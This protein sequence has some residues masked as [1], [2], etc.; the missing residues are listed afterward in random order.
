MFKAPKIILMSAVLA[1][2]L[3]SCSKKSSEESL[4]Q[5]KPASLRTL[6][7]ESNVIAEINKRAVAIKSKEEIIPLINQ[8]QELASK[9]KDDY[10]LQ[11]YALTLRPVPHFEGLIWRLRGVVEKSGPMHLSALS[12]ITKAYYRDYMY[13]PH[14]KASMDFLTIPSPHKNKK[15][16][17]V[18]EVQNFLEVTIKPELERSLSELNGLISTIDD[19]WSFDFDGHL[20]TG[21]DEQTNKVFISS[22]KRY[23]KVI[24]PHLLYMKSSLH[25]L[26]GGINYVVNYNGDDLP[27]FTKE[28]VKKTAINNIAA[29]TLMRKLPQV[30]TPREAIEVLNKKGTFRKVFRNFLTARKSKDEMEKN[31]NASMD[32]FKKAAEAELRGFQDTIAQSD[33]AMG[34]QYVIN[35]NLIKIGKE[36]TEHRL[37][38]LIRLYESAAKSQPMTV[39]SDITGA[40]IKVNLR[41]LF[42]PQD[43]LKAFLP[44]SS[45]FADV[46]RGGLVQYDNNSR[47]KEFSWDYQYGKPVSWPDPTF[48]GFI[49]EATNKNIYEL[50]RTLKLTDSLKVFSNFLPIP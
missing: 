6:A 20:I 44:T 12:A 32:H 25:R 22:N 38:E 37:K 17:S 27:R 50:A 13:G 49:P 48:A 47:S 29:A 40:Q 11:L 7:S 31:L 39:T 23:K 21:Y 8:V 28:M 14:V 16:E 2:S 35:P 4:T 33:P 15:F 45:D 18:S 30:A 9:K 10:A 46:K 26:L 19:S 42:K 34:R 5:A 43:D 41:T 1:T 36:D 3:S 24:K